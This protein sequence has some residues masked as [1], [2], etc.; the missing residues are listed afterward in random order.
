M[1]LLVKVMDLV[2]WKMDVLEEVEDLIKGAVDP[3]KLVV[4]RVL[5]KVGGGVEM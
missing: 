2:E 1:C 4:E 3:V 5:K